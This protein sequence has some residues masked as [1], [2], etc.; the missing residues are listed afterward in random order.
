MLK[1]DQNKFFCGVS[2]SDAS[3]RRGHVCQAIQITITSVGLSKA[4]AAV[5]K[6]I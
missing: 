3:P 2:Q 6:Q 4:P 5:Q 1:K